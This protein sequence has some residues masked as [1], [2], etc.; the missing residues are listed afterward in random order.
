MSKLMLPVVMPLIVGPLTFVVMQGL[1]ALSATIDALPPIAKRISVVVVATLLT[2]L[3]TWAGVDFNC[4]PN[5]VVNC[6][7]TVDKDA[8]KAVM[9]AAIAFLMHLVKQQKS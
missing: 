3:G 6:L 2:A 9:A 1:K 5:G 4:D 8:V 7:S